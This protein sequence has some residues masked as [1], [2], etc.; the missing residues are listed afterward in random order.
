MAK[1]YEIC[2]SYLD[3]EDTDFTEPE[4]EDIRSRYDMY[5]ILS[6]TQ[7]QMKHIANMLINKKSDK[8]IWRY[9]GI[10]LRHVNQHI[11]KPKPINY[12]LRIPPNVDITEPFKES[13]KED[14]E[15]LDDICKKSPHYRAFPPICYSKYSVDYNDYASIPEEEKKNRKLSYKPNPNKKTNL[16]KPNPHN[17]ANLNKCIFESVYKESEEIDVKAV[18]K[19]ELLD[20]LATFNNTNVYNSRQ[21]YIIALIDKDVII[22]TLI[23]KIMDNRLSD[24]AFKLI[25]DSLLHGHISS[26]TAITLSDPKLSTKIL[27]K[28]L[29][30]LKTDIRNRH[31]IID[32][33]KD[34]VYA[35]IQYNIQ[36]IVTYN[37]SYIELQKIAT[38]SR[39]YYNEAISDI[40]KNIFKY[41]ENFINYISRANLNGVYIEYASEF[42]NIIKPVNDCNRRILY[43]AEIAYKNGVSI[44]DIKYCLK[45]CGYSSSRMWVLRNMVEHNLDRYNTTIDHVEFNSAIETAIDYLYKSRFP[46]EIILEWFEG[47]VDMYG[48]RHRHYTLYELQIYMNKFYSDMNADMIKFIN[49][50]ISDNIKYKNVTNEAL[51]NMHICYK[52][53]LS[54]KEIDRSITHI[55]D[56][57]DRA[58]N[59]YSTL[60]DILAKRPIIF[61]IS[62]K[63]S[64]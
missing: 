40:I 11:P 31:G 14:L 35:F 50:F 8:D 47:L 4:K 43:N 55:R 48:I 46:I 34:C 17:K 10:R 58:K 59:A 51:V 28:L 1:N 63:E 32:I 19:K 61:N 38:I 5:F 22:R 44:E 7:Y 36:D 27:D 21:S 33:L 16:N 52:L 25:Y 57:G 9:L 30:L 64:F 53:G 56:Y 39:C 29:I 15:A 26:A 54:D 23:P 45:H 18:K 12:L 2:L 42:A 41:S 24:K 3:F 6:S 62:P 60:N 49:N 37:I 20:Y 13:L